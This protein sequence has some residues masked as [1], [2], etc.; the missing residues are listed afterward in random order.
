MTNI[1]ANR[2]SQAIEESGKSM[3]EIARQLGITPQSVRAW[4]IGKTIPDLSR[5]PSIARVTGKSIQWLQGISDDDTTEEPPG[6]EIISIPVYDAKASA[7]N[8]FMDFCGD[9]VVRRIDIDKNWLRKNI[10][11]SS[12]QNLSVITVNGD[13]MCPTLDDGDF[14]LVDTGVT[15]MKS[16]AVYVASVNDEIF[17][18]RFQKRPDGKLLMISDNKRY[19]SFVIG[20]ESKVRINGRVCH[21]WHGEKM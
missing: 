21:H 2:I 10:N 1:I 15:E 19:E 7:G 12:L 5:F 8:G 13:S 17:V 18:K 11:F 3:S 4:K 20:P 14:I 9:Q 16:D 6:D